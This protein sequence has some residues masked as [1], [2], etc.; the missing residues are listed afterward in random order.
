MWESWMVDGEASVMVMVMISFNSPPRQG[1]RMEFLVAETES[2]SLAAKRNSSLENVEP[3]YVF[4]SQAICSP[5]ERSRGARR[6]PHHPQARPSPARAWARCGPPVGLLRP[7]F[8]LRGSSGKIGLS[9]FFL[10]FFWNFDFLHK[11]KTS[12]QFC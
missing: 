9:V 12:R 11:N 1:A 5:K 3:P 10:G 8:W 2:L 6:Q 4:R 7:I